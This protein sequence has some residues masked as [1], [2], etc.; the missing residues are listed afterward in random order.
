MVRLHRGVFML[1]VQA[2]QNPRDAG[3]DLANVVA[4]KW[5]SGV[6][7]WW[8]QILL[9]ITKVPLLGDNLMFS[10]PS[11]V[12]NGFQPNNATH[13]TKE[14]SVVINTP[15]MHRIHLQ[16][17]SLE[18]GK[19]EISFLPFRT[20]ILDLFIG[21]FSNTCTFILSLALPHLQQSALGK[22]VHLSIALHLYFPFIA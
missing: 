2:P 3:A 5:Q 4:P 11:S 22:A 15:L 18:V 9:L 8:E 6:T 12:S 7:C 14:T 20:G 1:K 21:Q 13:N 10:P 17:S 19:K 16:G